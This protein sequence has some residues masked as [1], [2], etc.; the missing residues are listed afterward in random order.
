VNQTA[1]FPTTGNPA[2]PRPDPREQDPRVAEI[3]ASVR[4]AFSEK[5]F[6]GAS[7]QDLARAAGM[8]V[9]NF[10]RYFSSKAGI[11]AAI[12]ESDLCQVETDFA[13]VM[14]AADP[15]TELKSLVR[16]QLP[17]HSANRDSD[18]WAEIS[19]V[20]RRHSEIGAAALAMESRIRAALHSVIA[21]HTGLPLAEAA[22]RFAAEADF[23][24]L[25]FKA[26]S[27]S[28]DAYS[29]H[30]SRLNDLIIASIDQPLDTISHTARNS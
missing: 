5:G 26:S 9:G 13:K 14:S 12:I 25:L 7:M 2:D 20:A 17:Q 16:T 3:L 11:V 4:R 23:I 24:L 30:Q 6:D 29:S 18:L 8:S 10:Y 22:R 19:V 21:R 27:C 28:G 1:P 15:F